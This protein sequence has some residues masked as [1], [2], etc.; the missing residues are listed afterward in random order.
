MSLN[1]LKYLISVFDLQ[2]QNK[3]DTNSL[4]KGA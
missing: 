3:V 2:N 1:A 4:I